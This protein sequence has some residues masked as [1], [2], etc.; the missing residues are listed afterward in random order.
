MKLL[1]DTIQILGLKKPVTVTMKNRRGRDCDAFY[2]PHYSDR[3]GR[4]IG[5][6]ITIYTLESD[7]PFETLLAHEL[8]HA[9][10]EEKGRQEFHGEF[11]QYWA[12]ELGRVLGL[13]E[14]YLPEV[15]EE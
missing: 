10:Q 15:D 14:I 4:L 9:A 6:K 13:K 3:N 11:F 12:Q 7:R 5:H 1:H 2:M 8:I